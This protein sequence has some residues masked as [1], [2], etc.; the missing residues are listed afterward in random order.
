[1]G[2]QGDWGQQGC[3]P[4]LAYF[5]APLSLQLVLLPFNG[6]TACCSFFHPQLLF[7]RLHGCAQGNVLFLDLTRF[8]S[9]S[10]VCLSRMQYPFIC[11]VC[12]RG[13]SQLPPKEDTNGRDAL[14]SSTL[15]ACG[16]QGNYK[17]TNTGRSTTTFKS[18]V[19]D[20]LFPEETL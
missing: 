8:S 2:D 5:Y 6:C 1:M 10:D 11:K 17:K 19:C 15:T 13:I 7:L 16:R 12:Q 20:G 3:H 14:A 18:L 9:C 4:V